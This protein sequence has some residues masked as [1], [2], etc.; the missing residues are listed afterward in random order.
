MTTLAPS[1]EE[2]DLT[3]TAPALEKMQELTSQVDDSVKGIRIYVAGGGCSGISFG[4]TFADEINEDDAVRQ[5]DSVNIVV[6]AETLEHMRGVEIDYVD[7][8]NGNT[9]FVF[10]NLPAQQGGGCGGCGG[11]SCGDG[12]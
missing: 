5:L 8:G 1:L 11:G 9:S 7:Y 3:L 2:K 12:C 6:D 10:N 4:M